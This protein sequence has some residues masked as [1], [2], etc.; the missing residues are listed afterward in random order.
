MV[1]QAGQDFVALVVVLRI[2]Q[3]GDHVIVEQ[4]LSAQQA[5]V[6]LLCLLYLVSGRNQVLVHDPL[7]AARDALHRPLA[8]A[9]A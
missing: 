5:L 9:I 2:V 8:V 6:L 1:L 7:E 3:Q 4:Q